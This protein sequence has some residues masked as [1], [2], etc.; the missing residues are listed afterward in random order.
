M[1]PA[2]VYDRDRV[3]P[4]FDSLSG[5]IR[6]AAW[7]WLLDE[8]ESSN[9][10]AFGD[11]VFWCRLLETPFD[12]VRQQLIDILERRASRSFPRPDADAL[13]PVW[14]SVLAGV[15][16]GGRQK[17]KAIRQIVSALEKQPDRADRL[18]PVLSVALRSIRAPEMREALSAVVGLSE[19]RP[20]L[21]AAIA[22]HL[23]EVDV[24][25]VGETVW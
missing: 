18:L 4:F 6:T 2:E 22:R 16:R 14:C 8:K 13:T 21:A 17:L 20:E 7:V 9:A 5:P 19:S 23:P 10:A 1:G 25:P 24:Q 11:P 15:H 3:L 12:D